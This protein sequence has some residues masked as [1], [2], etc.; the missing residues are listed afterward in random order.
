V[1][2]DPDPLWTQ[3]FSCAGAALNSGFCNTDFDAQVQAQRSTLDASQRVA[4][5]VAAQKI[6]YAQVPA[7]YFEP[8]VIWNVT[9]PAVQDVLL[10]NDGTPMLDRVWIKR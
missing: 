8:K 3:Y 7:L 2:S 9:S 1:F 5:I 10:V 4:A 6:F